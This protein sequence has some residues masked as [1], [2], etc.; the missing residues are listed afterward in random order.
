[1]EIII[2]VLLNGF[3]KNMKYMEIVRAEDFRNFVRQQIGTQPYMNQ[4][5]RKNG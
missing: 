1:M 2:L 3:L 4:K 5:Q